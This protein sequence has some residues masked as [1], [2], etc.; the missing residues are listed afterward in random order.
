MAVS[1]YNL[2]FCLNSSP[3]TTDG[4]PFLLYPLAVANGRP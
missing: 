1:P 3:P 2:H 4:L